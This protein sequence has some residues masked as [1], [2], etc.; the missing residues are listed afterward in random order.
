LSF[1]QFQLGNDLSES[2]A[3]EDDNISDDINE[4]S[5]D[6]SRAH[7]GNVQTK[8]KKKRKKASKKKQALEAQKKDTATVRLNVF[9]PF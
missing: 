6:S 4:D 9:K 2:E 3:K 1:I 5:A 8:K 7:E